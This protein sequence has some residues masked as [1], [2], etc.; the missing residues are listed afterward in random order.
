MKIWFDTVQLADDGAE[1]V[2]G[3]RINGQNTGVAQVDILNATEPRLRDGLNERNTISFSISRTH[4]SAADAEVY[5]LTHKTEVPHTGILKL[6]A[7]GENGQEVIRWLGTPD[8]PAG[9]TM[10]D[11]SYLG[12]TTF[13]TYSFIG[14]VVRLEDPTKEPQS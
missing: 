9:L 4:A 6:Q 7:T 2:S 10:S 1:G 3:F 5:L 14:G 13:H 11:G 8:N 12:A